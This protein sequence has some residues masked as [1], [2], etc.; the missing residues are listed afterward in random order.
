M[1]QQDRNEALEQFIEDIGLSNE[2]LT[3]W[4]NYEIKGLSQ[5]QE[6]EWTA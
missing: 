1:T 2:E 4:D 6:T 3:Y 5:I